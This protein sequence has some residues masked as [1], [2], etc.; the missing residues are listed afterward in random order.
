MTFLF[1]DQVLLE[2]E[3]K[4][5]KYMSEIYGNELKYGIKQLMLKSNPNL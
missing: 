4:A 3:L 5:A 1:Y 2:E